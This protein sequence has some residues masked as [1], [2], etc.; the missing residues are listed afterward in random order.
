MLTGVFI[1]FSNLRRKDNLPSRM[2]HTSQPP[3]FCP[4]SF[5]PGLQVLLSV[6]LVCV[7]LPPTQVP[8][9]HEVGAGDVRGQQP[10]EAG[11]LRSRTQFP[12]PTVRGWPPMV[13]LG[14]PAPETASLG[15]RP[16]TQRERHALWGPR[17]FSPTRASAGLPERR[18]V[19]KARSW[20]GT[21]GSTAALGW[22]RVTRSREQTAMPRPRPGGSGGPSFRSTARRLPAGRWARAP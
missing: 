21:E 5:S 14:R 10:H 22:R 18:P 9:I 11:T 7:H 17:F 2:L 6:T 1:Y 8:P 4:L 20:I 12:L 3:L 19:P 16:R 15:P 13:K